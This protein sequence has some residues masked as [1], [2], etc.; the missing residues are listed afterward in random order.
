VACFLEERALSEDRVRYGVVFK[1]AANT[2]FRGVQ[3]RIREYLAARQRAS[4][5]QAAR[6]RLR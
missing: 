1:D 4:L 2:N 3:E 5:A 6:S